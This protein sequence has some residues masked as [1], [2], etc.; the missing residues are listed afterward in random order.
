MAGMLGSIKMPKIDQYG[1]Y[2]AS[3]VRNVGVSVPVWYIPAD[4]ASTTGT[5]WYQPRCLGD[6]DSLILSLVWEYEIRWMS[7]GF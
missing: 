4:T 1:Q 7:N 2:T 3:L 5:V 6:P